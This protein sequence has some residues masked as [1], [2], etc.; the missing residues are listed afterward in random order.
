MRYKNIDG[1][2]IPYTA[3]EETEAWYFGDHSFSKHSVGT[4]YTLSGQGLVALVICQNKEQESEVG[5]T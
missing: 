4:V 5:F 1:V 3:Q 2:K